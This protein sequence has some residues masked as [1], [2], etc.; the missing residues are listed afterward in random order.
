MDF[1]SEATKGSVGYLNYDYFCLILVTPVDAL[2]RNLLLSIM[3]ANSI[4]A[5][6]R[7]LMPA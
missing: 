1:C 5:N 4:R 2:R 3:T 7:N 6:L